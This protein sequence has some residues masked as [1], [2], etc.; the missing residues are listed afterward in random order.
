MTPGGWVEIMT[1]VE[2][3]L[4][5]LL[6]AFGYPSRRATAVVIEQSPGQRFTRVLAG[7]GVFWGLALAGLFIPVAHLVLV[8]SFVTAGIIIAAR[9]AREARR[10]LLVRGA[11]PR[12]GVPQEFNHGGRFMN[13]R[14]LSC[15]Q[16]HGNVTLVADLASNLP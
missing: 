4:P 16:C 13:G 11:C 7:L 12:C 8:P 15:P 2:T 1:T 9:R 10:L 6:T 3:E 5:A 14:S